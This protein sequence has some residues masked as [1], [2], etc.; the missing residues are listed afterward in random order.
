MGGYAN[1]HGDVE[2]AAS[3]LQQDGKLLLVGKQGL[4][5]SSVVDFAVLRVNPD[6]SPD[7]AFNGTGRVI[8][9]FGGQDYARQ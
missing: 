3:A 8:T 1:Y 6:G 5:T 4:W 2:P 7:S 9:D